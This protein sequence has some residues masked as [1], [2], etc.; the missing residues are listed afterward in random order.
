[1]KIL[2]F[3]FTFLAATLF[4]S[5]VNIQ[6]LRC[7]YLT[8]PVGIDIVNPRLSWIIE[9]TL[10]GERQTAFEI[11]V[12]SS[13]EKLAKNQGDLWDSGKV[14]SEQTS[15][16]EYKGKPL[17]SG[18]QCFWKVR[19]WDRNGKVADWS[20]P[21][22]W[23]MG[24]LDS[25]DW[26]AK[27]I[28]VNDPSLTE[29]ARPRYMRKSFIT[30]K[31]V[32]RATLYATALGLYELHLNGKRVGDQLLAPEWTNYNKRVQY[33]TY[34]VNEMLHAGS[35]VVGAIL[36]NGWYSGGW[37]KWKQK[38]SAIYGSEPLFLAQLEIEFT[39]GARQIIVTD[40]SWRG[41]VDGPLQFAGIYEGVTYDAGKEFPGWDTPIFNDSKWSVVTTPQAGKDFKVGNLVA[42][43]GN[44]IRATQQIKPVSI[45]EPKPGVY[46]Y[47]FDQNIVGWCRFKFHGRRGE[48]VELQHG[49]MRNPDGTVF[50]GNLTVVSKHRIQLDQ[51]T[52]KGNQ[53]ETF[54]PNFTY[55][56][57][58]YVEVRGLKK[59]PSIESLTGVIFHSDCPE[60]GE[61]TCSEPL[62]NRLAKNILWSQRGNYM[63]VPTDCPQRNER[64]GYTGDA[65]FF[66]RAA[67]YNMDVSAFFSRW[68]VD[69][70]EEAQMP[71]GHF[72]DHAPTFGP[73][74]GPN[75]GWSD[76][77]IICPYEIYRT[78]GDTQI[79]REHYAA[80]KR[81]LDWLTRE[82]KDFLFTG[83]VGNGD[84]LSNEGGASKEVIG[85]AYSAFDFQLMAEMADAIGEK[86][87]ATK[88]R[89]S[90][91]KITR[92]FSK[93][94]INEEGKIKESS[95]SGYA[96]AFT[97]GLVPPS[98]KEKMAE[99]FTGEVSRFD[100][101]PRTG[102]IG[103]PRLLPGLH[104]AGRDDDAY[105]ILLTKTAPSWLYPVSIGA[106]TI[107]ER[108]VAWDGKTP[109]GGM[110]SLNHYAFGAVGE[111]LYRM[112][113]GISEATPGYQKIRIEPVIREGITW[114]K[115]S[116]N[117]IHGKI[118]TAW[119]VNGSKLELN[120]TIPANTTATVFVPANDL[121][122]V[123]ESGK[124][125]AKADGVK[126]LRIEN[127]KVVYTVESGN[128]HFESM[129][130]KNIK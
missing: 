91:D 51:Y 69:V 118:G 58:Q 123:S 81:N 4:A 63:G 31:K 82:S 56:G 78:Y 70:C 20:K 61:F 99:H 109:Q 14:E 25:Q 108:W 79:I 83:K 21:A 10:R 36:G 9:S 41:I 35:N 15:Q 90:A 84:W 104:L 24:L 19:I 129:L 64:C 113:G 119:K 45:T 38:L 75:I 128:Y 116:Y 101:H 43:R 77:G 117:S 122:T 121:S 53:E 72:A 40:S 127:D 106:T 85:T 89:D 80:M 97:M 47:A 96:L 87:D 65:Q 100:W 107:W 46:V 2:H 68:L 105:K 26:K 29:W 17:I 52:F 16:L 93:A 74:D 88:F 49:E 98:L 110:N 57:F 66:M 86:E 1:M 12:A 11:L 22:N 50:L 33:Q 7:E 126:F 130:P 71:D 103:T 92:A 42:Q 13:A 37:Q 73:G 111:Y 5:G 62:L 114:A 39:D 23:T 95:Q 32:H 102:F 30:S 34:D 3:I 44:P 76:A 28:G 48:T 125:I 27:W 18:V 112:V 124:S 54:E 115:T 67:V 8:N 6:N 60:V 120:L 55:H 94:Y 59:R